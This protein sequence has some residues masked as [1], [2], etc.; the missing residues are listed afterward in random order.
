MAKRPETNH[1]RA[2]A[3]RSADQAMNAANFG[4][5]WFREIAEQGLNQSKAVL[6]GYLSI[7]RKAVESVDRQASD[8]SNRSVQIAEET[9]SNA[10]DFAHKLVSVRDPQQLAT[11]QTEFVSRQAA[12]FSEQMKDV[13]QNMMKEATDVAER[14]MRAAQ[15]TRRRSA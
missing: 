14:S 2:F 12:I 7:S 9:L 6:D 11:L 5:N 3:H 10:Y 8:L 1:S 4:A 15:S 13:S